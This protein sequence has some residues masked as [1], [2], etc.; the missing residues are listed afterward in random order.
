MR[1]KLNITCEDDG[2][3]KV[4]YT[5]ILMNDVEIQHTEGHTNVIMITDKLV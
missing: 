5:S 3:T 1:L 4:P 2:K